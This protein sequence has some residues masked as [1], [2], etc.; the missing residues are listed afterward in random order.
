MDVNRL[1]VLPCYK[2]TYLIVNAF[3]Y[4]SDYH[5]S[6]VCNIK[7]CGGNIHSVVVIIATVWW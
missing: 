3:R 6:A 2:G 1:H 5:N 4:Y 7:Q